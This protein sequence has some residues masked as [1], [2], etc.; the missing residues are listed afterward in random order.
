MKTKY[1]EKFRLVLWAI[2]CPLVFL[3]FGSYLGFISAS[4]VA[5]AETQSMIWSPWDIYSHY[6]NWVRPVAVLLLLASITAALGN[7]LVLLAFRIVGLLGSLY[8]IIRLI[9]LKH[10]EFDV[11]DQTFVY[12]QYLLPYEIVLAVIL[13]ILLLIESLRWIED[14]KS[15][16]SKLL[17]DP[18]IS[19]VPMD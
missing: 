6:S 12:S 9:Q 15:G 3:I 1:L 16:K 7:H 2:G 11:Y 4:T 19:R 8:L 14:T 5:T 13:T 10:I 18:T 17:Q